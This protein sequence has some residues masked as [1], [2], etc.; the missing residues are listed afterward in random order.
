MGS[1]SIASLLGVLLLVSPVFA[2][3]KKA[4][5]ETVWQDLA[6]DD[7]ARVTRAALILGRS[8]D[9]AVDFLKRNL[10]PVKADAALLKRWVAELDSED[11][12]VR[13]AAQEELEYQGKYIKED[14]TKAKEKTE[15][16]EVRKR[17]GQLLEKIEAQE[18][19]AKPP[20]KMP[21]GGGIQ[22]RSVSISSVNGQVRIVVDGVPIDL[23]PRIIV[24]VGPPRV[25]V[26]A[27]RA[28]GVLEAMD[29]PAARQ[30][31]EAIAAG[32]A[33]AMPTVEA[34]AALDR[35]GKK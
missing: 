16:A 23:T 13:S 30:L 25:W 5:F 1:R 32:E 4:S 12:A 17:I 28:I 33:G 22:G 24:P 2:G 21:G 10:R 26:R 27:A 11:S 19:A 29:T 31:L 35:L 20:E 14:L 18:K 15:S 8:P 6:G 7:Q 9:A 34:R 3:E